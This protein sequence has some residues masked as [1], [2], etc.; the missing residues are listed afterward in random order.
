[1][2][3][4]LLVGWLS[5]PGNYDHRKSSAIPPAPGQKSRISGDSKQQVATRIAS[6]LQEKGYP[7]E[8]VKNVKNKI[9]DLEKELQKSIQLLE[10][11]RRMPYGGRSSKLNHD[12]GR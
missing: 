6:L 11:I 2:C 3:E 4:D 10:R 7:A 9:K 5:D 12:F 1:M 8:T